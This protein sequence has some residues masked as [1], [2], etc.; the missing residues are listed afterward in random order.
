M[1]KKKKPG[2]LHIDWRTCIS[3]TVVKGKTSKKKIYFGY[4]QLDK[5]IYLGIIYIQNNYLEK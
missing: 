1:L 5:P 4:I 3:L 2:V